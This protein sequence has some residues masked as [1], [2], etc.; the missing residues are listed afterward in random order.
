MTTALSPS[1]KQQFFTAAGVPLV[2]G[3]LYTYAAGT[4]TPL[5]T[6]VDSA[7]VTANTNPVIMDSRGEANI[8]LLPGLAYK[9]VLK[10][11]DDTTIW[12]VD[13]IDLG[14]NFANVIITGGTI[15]GVTIG[16]IDPGPATFTT[17]RATDDVT[18][19]GTG[20]ME[21]PSGLTADRTDTPSD[22]MIRYNE[23]TNKYEGNASVA[24]ATISTITHSGTTATVTTSSAH[25]L[26]TDD[27][28][29]VSGV[30][31]SNYNGSYGITVTGSTTFTYVMA[32]TP[33]T[34]ATVIGS[35][36][37]HQWLEFTNQSA[38]TGASLIPSGTTAQ[39]PVK[40]SAGFFR[41][42]SSLG[43]FEGYSGTTWSSV[44]NIDVSNDTSTNSDYYPVFAKAT[45]G[46]ISTVYTSNSNLLYNPS[47]GSLK[48]SNLSDGTNS[49]SS[50]NCIKGSA[51]AWVNFNGTTS[52]GTIRASYNVSS[53]TYN[54]VGDY[55]VN[56][57]NAFSDANY[58]AIG[59]SSVATAY[60]I[61][62]IPSQ[63]SSTNT[64]GLQTTTSVRLVT[65]SLGN[66]GTESPAYV[67]VACFR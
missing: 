15:N 24:G 37:V 2:G 23:T 16:N 5:A 21:I 35:Y 19:D 17:L 29:T 61:V 59:T 39:R 60:T 33:S 4:S 53:V 36:I 46:A 7:G 18:F 12:T 32:S 55:T 63:A 22:G 51:K 58:T 28:I 57:T 47:T 67:Q 56:F 31:P 9:F 43:I 44:G 27:Y 50:T 45:T 25:G 1:A 8:W 6:Y 54:G 20:Q 66:T 34:D 26:S 14:I 30:S 48:I 64:S 38:I 11:P 3:K 42:N 62:C 52:P 40:A 41:H 13:D 49:T 10:D 65:E